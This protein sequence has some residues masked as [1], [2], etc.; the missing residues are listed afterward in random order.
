MKNKITLRFTALIFG[1]ALFLQTCPAQLA[2]TGT[3]YLQ[4]FN[5]LA[6]GLPAGW[7]VRTNATATSLGT[8]MDIPVATKTWGDTPGEFRNCAATL[9]NAG[10]NFLGGESATIQNNCTN[11]ALAVRQ[12][13]SFGDPGAAFVL[14][15][16]NTLNLTNLAFT[17]D[18]DL[19]KTNAHSTDWKL[20]YAVGDSPAVFTTLDTFHDPGAFGA[21]TRTCALGKDTANQ[22]ANVWIRVVALVASSGTNGSR[23]TFGVDNFSLTWT[24]LPTNP[25]VITSLVVGSDGARVNFSGDGRD[26]TNAFILQSCGNLADGFTD[27]TACIARTMSDGF[28]AV[29]SNSASQRFYRVKRR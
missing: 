23:E 28:Q 4:D 21:I 27:E 29:C 6:G 13:A 20:E 15:I 9:S 2:L 24:V 5:S 3:N 25:P 22:P 10:T 8:S 7:T 11:R 18:L 26:D 1:S 17:A 12:T 16:A 14:Q 19:L